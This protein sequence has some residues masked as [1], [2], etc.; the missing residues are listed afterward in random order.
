[1]PLVQHQSF[2][3]LELFVAAGFEPF[4]MVPGDMRRD[5]ESL[6]SIATKVGRVFVDEEEVF[7]YRRHGFRFASAAFGLYYE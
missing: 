6:L 4:A 2:G 1:M 5:S 3:R 7:R